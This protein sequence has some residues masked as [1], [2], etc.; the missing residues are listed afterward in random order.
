MV[1]KQ[2]MEPGLVPLSV[3][4]Y[5][6]LHRARPLVMP[7]LVQEGVWAIRARVQ[8]VCLPS[9]GARVYWTEPDTEALQNCR[10]FTGE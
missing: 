6:G 4:F 8:V 1:M 5:H 3:C 2:E 10:C 9:C 7:V